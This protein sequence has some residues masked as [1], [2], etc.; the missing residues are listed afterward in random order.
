ML[1]TYVQ[2]GVYTKRFA[3][4]LITTTAWKSYIANGK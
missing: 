4:S 1:I 2:N 3:A